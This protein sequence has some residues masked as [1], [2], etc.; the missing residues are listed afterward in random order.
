MTAPVSV[1]FDERRSRAAF[2]LYHPKG[3]AITAEMVE[4]LSAAL[5][6]VAENPHLKLITIQG[7][8]AD[9]S[10]GASVPEHAPDRIGQVLP[11][12][13]RLLEDLLDAPAPTAAI[14]QG[15]CLGGGFELALA[16][17]FLFAA[18]DAVFGLPEIAL[19][20]FPPA[21]SALLPLRAGAAR[22]ARAILTG[23]TQG[24]AEWEEAGL[25]HFRAPRES[26]A[27][28]V[29]QW[30]DEHLAPKS[31]AALRHAAA[32]AR[33]GLLAHFRATVPELERLYL[34]D[35]MR[36][37]DAVE[38]IAAFVEKRAPRWTDR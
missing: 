36:T 27:A 5:G 16:C 7:A 8:G 34:D 35:L 20:V 11:A 9:F 2:T 30:F 15:R 23:A 1:S 25:V 10:F 24:A 26:L 32:A 3:N 37:Q 18:D 29:D 19:G 38:G 17:D 13:H 28:R 33:H 4:A 31:A 21:A 14:V 12:M 6:P 22:A